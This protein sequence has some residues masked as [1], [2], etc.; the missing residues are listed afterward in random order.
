MRL[1]FAFGVSHDWHVSEVACISLVRQL[2]DHHMSGICPKWQVADTC[3][4][5]FSLVR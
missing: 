3:G 4:S 5:L 1:Q 2:V